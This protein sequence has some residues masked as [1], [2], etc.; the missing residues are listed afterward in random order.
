M[1]RT[2]LNKKQYIIV[3]L[4]ELFASK[5]M[6]EKNGNFRQEFLKWVSCKHNDQI[7]FTIVKNTKIILKYQ[8]F[9]FLP[10]II[11]DKLKN[12]K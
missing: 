2:K 1:K 4:K 8:Y 10:M 7:L 3:C 6:I 5:R 11:S 12:P 9:L